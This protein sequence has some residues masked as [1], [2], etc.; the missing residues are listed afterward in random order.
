M[1][2]VELTCRQLS[3]TVALDLPYLEQALLPGRSKRLPKI[4]D[5]AKQ[6]E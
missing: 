3:N 4:I 1:Y 5:M 2:K 6:F